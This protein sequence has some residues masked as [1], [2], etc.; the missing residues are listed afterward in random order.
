MAVETSTTLDR[1]QAIAQEFA[2]DRAARQQRRNLERVDFDRLA[3]AGFLLSGVPSEMGGIWESTAAT[4]RGIC[5]LLRALAHGDS[6]VALVAS[7]HPAVLCFWL[8]TLRVPAPFEAAWEAQRQKVFGWAKEGAWWGT[9]TSEPGSGGD[10]ADTKARAQ[11]VPQGA[12]GTP[13]A[14]DFLLSGQKHFGSGSGIASYMITTAVP[15]GESDPDWFYIPVEHNPFDGSAGI[16][17]VA[18][19]DG[20]G[21][22]A[23]QSHGL[24]FDDCPA[25]RFAWPGHLDDLIGGAAPFNA[26]IFTAVV[27]GILETAVATARTQLAPKAESLRP[28]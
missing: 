3:D 24:A 16:T 9:I 15:E 20:H 19:W 5:E 12:D 7:M 27:L 17:L 25:E 26:T 11:R 23:T 8:P 22:R 2:A 4:T 28:Y 1:I 6:S 10:V 14:G 18:P 13:T 21:M